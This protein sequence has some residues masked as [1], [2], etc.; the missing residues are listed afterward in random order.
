M[1]E[2]P[3]PCPFCGG[4]PHVGRVDYPRTAYYV[5]CFRTKCPVKPSSTHFRTRGDAIAVWNRRANN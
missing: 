4:K 1:S 3:L 5:M 2:K